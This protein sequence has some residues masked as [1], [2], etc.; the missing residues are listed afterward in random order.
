MG[1]LSVA[2][3]ILSVGGHSIRRF[4]SSFRHFGSSIRRSGVSIRPR[5]LH[6]S[7]R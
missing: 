1:T 5:A 7:L 3:A 6:P 2:L 4:G